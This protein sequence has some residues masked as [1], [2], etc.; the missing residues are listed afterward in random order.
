MIY[1]LY[2]ECLKYNESLKD[3]EDA[4]LLDLSKFEELTEELD[5]IFKI[6][7]VDDEYPVEDK[8]NCQNDSLGKKQKENVFSNF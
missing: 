7:D 2:E 3:V 4:G 8:Q 1:P 5:K 6:D